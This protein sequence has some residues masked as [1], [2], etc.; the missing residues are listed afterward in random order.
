MVLTCGAEGHG[1]PNV[2]A[3]LGCIHVFVCSGCSLEHMG[4]DMDMDM[5]MG[6]HAA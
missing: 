6:L 5:D 2:R 1:L 3:A 4:M